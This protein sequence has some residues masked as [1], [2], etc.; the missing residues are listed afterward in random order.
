[1]TFKPEDISPV[2]PIKSSPA[3]KEN[4]H[5][6]PKAFNAYFKKN[7]ST[8]TP[9]PNSS[10]VSPFELVQSSPTAAQPA[11]LHELMQKTEQAQKGLGD[12]ATQLKA[13]ELKN[14]N[15]SPQA[16]AL[17]NHLQEANKNLQAANQHLQKFTP[18]STEQQQSSS[19]NP[20]L[21][22]SGGSDELPP[23][24]GLLGKLT[25]YV[26][27]GQNHIREAQA[28]LMALK[29]KGAE[30]INPANMLLIQMSLYKAQQTIEMTSIMLS[31]M[32][33]GL[34]NTMNTQL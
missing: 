5:P 4:I 27:Q 31:K 17:S 8:T 29:D 28:K 13:P 33:E 20:S 14:I 1:M 30:Q 10:K 21:L 2:N 32:I 15:K 22:S 24:G 23:P 3:D 7:D 11:S 6:D 9:T 12:L 26:M 18:N 19:L 34:K 16:Q 25:Q